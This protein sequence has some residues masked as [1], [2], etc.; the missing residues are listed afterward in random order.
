MTNSRHVMLSSDGAEK[1]A[2]ENG[3]EMIDN[4]YFI[5]EERQNQLQQLKESESRSSLKQNK[6]GTVGCAALDKDGN[7]AAG[8]STGGISNKQFGRVGDS[9]IIG[10]GTYANNKTCAVSSTGTGE[11]FIRNVI[12]YDI[13]AK[14]EYQG[15][16]LLEAAD[17]VI[18]K[19][20][21]ELGG[22]GGIIGID[23]NANTAAVFN[24]KG[25]F[26][27]EHTSTAGPIIE[28]Y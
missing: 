19:K 5:T 1:F 2:Q 18:N 16:S 25:M 17:E 13:S 28:F 12:A 6:Y 27:A 20:L 14:M 15:K 11:Y 7:L 23:K 26:R 9:P 10:A 24:T 22:T 3:I 4:E 8:T 21:S